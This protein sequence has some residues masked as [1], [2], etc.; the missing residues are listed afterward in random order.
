MRAVCF[1]LLMAFGVAF[2]FLAAGA[3]AFSEWGLTL[4][5]GFI[6]FGCFC[7]AADAVIGG[8]Q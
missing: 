4:L 2:L 1:A 7:L 6:G 8:A 3:L 5:T